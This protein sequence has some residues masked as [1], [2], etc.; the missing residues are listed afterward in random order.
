MPF[1]KS[2]PHPSIT[3]EIHV[4]LAG[5]DPSNFRSYYDMETSEI[6]KCKSKATYFFFFILR[7]S[8]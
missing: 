8:K 3:Y 2:C 1:I 4:V 7:L 5:H 6:K